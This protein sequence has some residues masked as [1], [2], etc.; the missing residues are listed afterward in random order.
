MKKIVKYILIIIVIAFTFLIARSY[1]IKKI[2]PLE[3]KEE[4]FQYSSEFDVD[5]YLVSAIIWVESK[6]DKTALS[7]KGAVGLMQVMPETGQ[8]IAK[9]IGYDGY[10]ESM[11]SSPEVNIRF[12][13]W[14][15]SY[16]DERFGGKRA[17]ISAAYNGGP[18]RV[19]AWID[20]E[21]YSE[22][23]ELVNIPIK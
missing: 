3:Y 23:R 16:L 1:I 19:A 20:D 4:I 9:K 13:C 22:N 8:W 18:N 10:M 7:D 14:Y 5:P 15:I 17:H 2:Y 21:R 6:Y 11:L 12:G